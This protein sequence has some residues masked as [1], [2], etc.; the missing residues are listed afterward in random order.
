MGG[1]RRRHCVVTEPA[2]ASCTRTS[3]PRWRLD[4]VFAD[5]VDAQKGALVQKGV[6]A[7]RRKR[8][9]AASRAIRARGAAAYLVN[10]LDSSARVLPRRLPSPV[11]ERRTGRRG[12][13]G[14]VEVDAGRDAGGSCSASRSSSL[15]RSSR[16]RPPS[17]ARHLESREPLELGRDAPPRVVF[18][19]GNRGHDRRRGRAADFSVADIDGAPSSR[20]RARGI[21]PSGGVSARPALGRARAVPGGR[22]PKGQH[23]GGL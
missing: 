14:R 3:T 22:E 9:F 18:V 23:D 6:I 1:R 16:Q 13:S 2:S 8:Q 10:E 17:A 5:R 12:N 19:V 4:R 7:R 11:G 20:D 21:T 15:F